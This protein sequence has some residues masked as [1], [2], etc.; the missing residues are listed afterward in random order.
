MGNYFDSLHVAGNFVSYF[1]TRMVGSAFAS[2]L[3]TVRSVPATYFTKM[4][5]SGSEGFLK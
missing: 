2:P 1:D 4:E 3:A 5:L